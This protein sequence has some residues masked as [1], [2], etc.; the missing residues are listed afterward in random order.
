MKLVSPLEYFAWFAVN[1]FFQ[2]VPLP[3]RVKFFA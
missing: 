1:P 3:L 2:I